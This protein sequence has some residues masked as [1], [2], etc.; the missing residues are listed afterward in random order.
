MNLQEIVSRPITSPFEDTEMA[1]V[2]EEYIFEKKKE[3]IKIDLMS[4]YH[5]MFSPHYFTFIN[6]FDIAKEYYNDKAKKENM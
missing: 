3:R 1:Y 2:I 5:G 4:V 6:C